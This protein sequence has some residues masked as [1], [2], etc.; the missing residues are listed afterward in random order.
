MQ[1]LSQFQFCYFC[2]GR[3]IRPEQAGLS[4]L[5][6]VFKL[7]RSA[8]AQEKS[9]P[10]NPVSVCNDSICVQR[11]CVI[12]GGIK[13]PFLPPWAASFSTILS[14]PLLTLKSFPFLSIPPMILAS[15]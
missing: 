6:R 14:P 10:D 11:S 9:G 1:K 2:Q 3:I 8:N 12:V 7:F 15:F 4:G 5:K 13:G